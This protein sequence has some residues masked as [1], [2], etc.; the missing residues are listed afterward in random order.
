MNTFYPPEMK[1]VQY[2]G[3]DPGKNGA[4]VKYTDIFKSFKMETL[5]GNVSLLCEWFREQADICD[6]PLVVVEKI[7]TFS[8]DFGGANETPEQRNARIGRARQ[9]DK[10]KSHYSEL[11]TAIKLSKMPYVDITPRSWQSYLELPKEKDYT[12]RKRRFK[13]AAQE[14]APMHKVYGWN[15]DAVLLIEFAIKKL[16]FDKKY[17]LNKLKEKQPEQKIF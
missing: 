2:F 4:I 11:L 17:I 9:L 8:K 7:S 5:H 3:V 10:M 16:H 1:P 12:I 14:F 15:A 13:A 6:N